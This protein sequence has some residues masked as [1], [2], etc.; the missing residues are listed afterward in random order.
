MI[1]HGKEIKV[2]A[3]NSNPELAEHICSELYRTLG[4][5]DVA[6]FADGEC[7]VSVFEPVRGKDVFI[8]QSTCN[9]VN[10]NLMEL[11]IMID[12]M[13][14]A[15][16]G[17]ITA[18]IPYF[19]YA[20]QDRKAKSRDPISAKLVANLITT[21][22]ADRVL[23]MDLHAAQI[24]GFFDIPVDN[25]LGS[26]L[27]VKHFVNMFGKGNEDVMVVSP[28]VGSTAR[29]RAFS[30][31]LGVNMAI[32]DKR[33]EKAN[34]S[35]VMNIIGNV[36]GKTCILLDDIVDTAGSLCGAA[37]AISEIG[38]A[39]K[40]YACATHGVLSGPAIERIENSCIEELLLL[41]TIPYPTDKPACSKIKYISTAPVFAEA[42]RRIYEEVSISNLFD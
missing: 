24:Q 27:F 25:L 8:V 31:K 4:K 32:V 15:S 37:K 22:G 12:A 34:Q 41:D 19:G 3:G 6:Q 35:E 39:K 11:L 20:R 9:H 36:E 16:A 18:V 38:G 40:V 7:S 30:M 14:R 17:R 5:A 26:H 29:V 42:I 33:R 21:A 28:D 10:D 2:F 13:R 23:T 1:S